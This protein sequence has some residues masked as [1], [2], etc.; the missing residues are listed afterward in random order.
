MQFGAMHPL[1]VWM[2]PTTN[3]QNIKHQHAYQPATARATLQQPRVVSVKPPCL[4]TTRFQ[5]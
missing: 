4:D 2:H 1:Q 3:L 5:K